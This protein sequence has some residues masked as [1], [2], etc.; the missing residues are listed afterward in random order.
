MNDLNITAPESVSLQLPEGY[1]IDLE[2]SDLEQ[3]VIKF[4][5]K[6]SELVKSWEDLEYVAGYKVDLNSEI[7]MFTRVHTDYWNQNIWATIEQAEASIAMA[8]LSQLM[9]Q[10]NGDWTPDWEDDED[11]SLEHTIT[12]NNERAIKDYSWTSRS[13]LVFKSEEIRDE[14]LELHRDLIE[15]AKP[16]L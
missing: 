15:K 7:R 9:K 4:R 11:D 13:F 14:F 12:F 16:L 1:E 5:E 2:K 8:M 6:S 3:G 10:A